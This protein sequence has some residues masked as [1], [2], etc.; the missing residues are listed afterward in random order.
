VA[1]D[2]FLAVGRRVPLDH[3]A[4]WA[5][6]M[7]DLL[8][9]THCHSCGASVNVVLIGYCGLHCSKLCWKHNELEAL[10]DFEC[11]YGD[12]GECRDDHAVSLAQSTR[13]RDVLKGWPMRVA[14]PCNNVTIATRPPIAV[15]HH[16]D[17]ID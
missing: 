7:S 16:Y 4:R 3:A 8:V 5:F 14:Q 12:G 13:G 11:P 10:C 9:A 1:A 17:P 2:F 15:T 6:V